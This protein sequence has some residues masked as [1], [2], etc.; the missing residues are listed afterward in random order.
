MV[1][2]CCR[3]GGFPERPL[4]AKRPAR[5][6]IKNKALH[7]RGPQATGKDDTLPDFASEYMIL[8]ITGTVK[9]F[10]IINT[11]RHSLYKPIAPDYNVVY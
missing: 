8:H 11:F 9:Y 5:N 2:T 4:R 10:F 7:Q 6:P 3:N 1:I